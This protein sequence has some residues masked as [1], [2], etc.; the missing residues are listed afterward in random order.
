MSRLQLAQCSIDTVS[1]VDLDPVKDGLLTEANDSGYVSRTGTGHTTPNSKI[2]QPQTPP[3]SSG[4]PILFNLPTRGFRKRDKVVP[5]LDKEVDEPTKLRFQDVK[6]HFDKLLLEHV[7]QSSKPGTRY[8]PISTRLIMMGT[9]SE[10]ASAYIIV[11]CQPEQK[12]TIRRFVRGANIQTLCGVGDDGVPPLKIAVSDIA[13]RLRLAVDVMIDASQEAMAGSQKTTLC[14]TPIQLKHSSGM[15]RNAT[16]GGF[17]KILT[18]K[19]EIR[20]FGITAA[21]PVLELDVEKRS[22]ASDLQASEKCSNDSK[23]HV[24]STLDRM[25]LELAS[26][27]LEDDGSAEERPHCSDEDDDE[28][29]SLDC[30]IQQDGPQRTL[31]PDGK[32]WI[33]QTPCSIGSIIYPKFPQQSSA[34]D[35]KRQCYDWALFETFNYEAN[36]LSVEPKAT[37]TLSDKMPGATGTRPIY[38]ISASGVKEG[39]LS[40]CS[41]SIVLDF[42]TEFVDTYLVTMT[43]EQGTLTC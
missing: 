32:T 31:Q 13:P 18:D 34:C 21:H 39:Q 2:V 4:G 41:G 15:K 40:P 3:H 30:F 17:V 20:I 37:I 6:P 38:L 14:G 11:F 10:N 25:G 28:D 12:D 33:F 29:I 23:V 35:S 1:A 26:S 36:K 7:L 27:E 19:G 43:G 24:A 22:M 5:F 42:G 16:F 9:R 8:T